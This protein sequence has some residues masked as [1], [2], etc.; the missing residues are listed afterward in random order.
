MCKVYV[1]E[2]NII[3]YMQDI[4]KAIISTYKKFRAETL[5]AEKKNE[6]IFFVEFP[7]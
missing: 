6:R 7:L 5:R 4:C 1:K 2:T 3:R